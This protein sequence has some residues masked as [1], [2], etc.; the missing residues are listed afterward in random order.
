VD[1][2]AAAA[3]SSALRA[4]A[5]ATEVA[6]RE[7][8]SALRQRLAAADAATKAKEREL[9]RAQRSLQVGWDVLLTQDEG[10]HTAA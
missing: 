4:K 6:A 5:D 10:G 9:A 8:V 3:D 2:R 1:A 7:E